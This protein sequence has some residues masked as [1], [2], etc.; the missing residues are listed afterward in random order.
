MTNKLTYI[1]GNAGFAQ[2]LYDQIFSNTAKTFG[3]FIELQD[4]KAYVISESGSNP[5]FYPKNCEFVLGTGSKPWRAAFIDKFTN[6]Y[7]LNTDFFPNITHRTAYISSLS[8]IGVGNVFCPFSTLNGNPI[9][10][11]FNTLGMYA[12]ISHDC[13][14]NSNNIL[15][16]YAGVMGR[17]SLGSVN[18]LGANSIITP[19]IRIGDDNTISA[20]EVVFDDMGD[21]EFFQSGLIYKKP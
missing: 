7:E 4:D 8:T 13:T 9:L 5:F 18:F 11:N 17:C 10:G 12:G 21:R 20:G 1:L 19:D 3:G 2:E 14:I 16:P 6:A 15:S